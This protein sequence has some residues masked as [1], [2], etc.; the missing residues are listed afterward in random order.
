MADPPPVSSKPRKVR[1]VSLSFN[2]KEYFTE[3][4]ALLMKAAVPLGQSLSSMEKA[5]KSPNMRKALVQIQ[6]DIQDGFSLADGLQRAGLVSRQTLVLIRLGE[7]SGHLA[8]NLE[9]AAEQ[10]EKRHAFRAKVRS[11][12]LYP[13]FVLSLTLIIGLAV[14]WFLLPRLAVT[15]SGMGVGLPGISKFTIGIGVF[16]K[17]HGIIAIPLFLGAIASIGYLIFGFPKTKFI[18][19]K[20]LFLIPGI[21]RLLKQVEVAQFG[22][23]LGTLLD[24]GLLV[25]QSLT[26]LS[27]TSPY[28]N[29]Q[30]FYGYLAKSL[31]DGYSF[32]DALKKYK[33]SD[34]MLPDAVQQMLIAGENSGSL[35]DVLKTVGRSYEA[36]AEITTGNLETI[37][38]PI[39]LLFVWAGVMLVAVSVIIPIYSLVGGLGK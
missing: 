13:T 11:A 17:A 5:T 24:A 33:G 7:S 3:N 29:Y 14:A 34:K 18:G 15:F 35:P 6:A 8:Q 31:E 10:E 36:K 28:E 30:K 4:L 21:S 19:H 32:E 2:D 25:T 16:L 39:L 22:Y 26:L 27:T 23:L 1:K 38:E 20:I 12:L 37:L 9:L